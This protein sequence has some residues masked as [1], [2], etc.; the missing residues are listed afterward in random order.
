MF[1]RGKTLDSTGNQLYNNLFSC[2]IFLFKICLLKEGGGG[3][4]CVV[5]HQ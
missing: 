4:V 1:E 2:M 5:T 3:K